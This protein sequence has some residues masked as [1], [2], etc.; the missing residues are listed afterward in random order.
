MV[1]RNTARADLSF[2]DTLRA[3]TMGQRRS[4]RCQPPRTA[5]L[6]CTLGPPNP[7]R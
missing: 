5:D 4:A 2:R 7:D 3:P 1:D 6:L